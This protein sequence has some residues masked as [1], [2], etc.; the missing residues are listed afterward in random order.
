M[1]LHGLCSHG[2]F[3]YVFEKHLFGNA[4]GHKLY[5]VEKRTKYKFSPKAKALGSDLRPPKPEI[6]NL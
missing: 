4:C 6:E 1:Q 2:L 5:I 3:K